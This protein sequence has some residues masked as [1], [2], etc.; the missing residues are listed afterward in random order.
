MKWCTKGGF[1]GG[2]RGGLGRPVV[3]TKD[4]LGWPEVEGEEGLGWLVGTGLLSYSFER[5][6]ER[7]R[8]VFTF[9]F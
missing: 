6:R 3:E 5:E 1:D 4:S 2:D 8:E 9:F 7:E